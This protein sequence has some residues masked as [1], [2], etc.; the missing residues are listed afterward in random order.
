VNQSQHQSSAVYIENLGF[1]EIVRFK[2]P[3]TGVGDYQKSCK[4]IYVLR[5]Y[6]LSLTHPFWFAGTQFSGMENQMLTSSYTHRPTFKISVVYKSDR[7]E[8][9]GLNES[10]DVK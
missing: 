7:C 5:L 3:D 9:S 1:W 6:E 4:T 10:E 2:E 8:I